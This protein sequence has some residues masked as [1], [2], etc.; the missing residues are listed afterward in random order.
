MMHMPN[1]YLSPHYTDCALLC[2]DMQNDFVLP[3]GSATIPG[4]AEIAPTVARLAKH[5]REV[6]RLV[7]HAVRLYLPD[8]SNVD[9]CRRTLMESGRQIVHPGSHGSQLADAL[10]PGNTPLSADDLLAGGFQW[11]R[12]DAEAVFYKPRWSAFHATGLHAELRHRKIDTL[13]I[14]GCNYPNCPRATLYD[15]T[16]LDYRTVLATDAISGLYPKGDDEMRGIGV[17]LA[18]SDEIAANLSDPKHNE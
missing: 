11:L 9:V 3:E 4:T 10:N 18:T 1:D 16:S 2:I 7:Y 8:G 6:G 14:A 17:T 12:H 13:V 5:F 15:A